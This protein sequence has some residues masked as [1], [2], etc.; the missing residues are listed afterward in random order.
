MKHTVLLFIVLSLF[1]FA[2]CSEN[3][4]EELFKTAQF[5]EL[6]NN[7]EHAEKLYREIAEKYPKS[8]YARKAEESLS[9]LNK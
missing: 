2:A 8:D 7:R 3:R 6:Q 5:E 1:L 9:N 4:A